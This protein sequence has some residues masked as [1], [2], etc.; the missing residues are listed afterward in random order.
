MIT[1]A[2]TGN[3]EVMRTLRQLS[4]IGTTTF[5][6]SLTFLAGCTGEIASGED[7]VTGGGN[8]TGGSGS[9]STGSGGTD[10]PDNGPPE[11]CIPGIPV[12]TQ[13]PR[14][15]NR[16]YD[17][18]VRDLLGVTTVDSKLPSEQLVDD[19]DGPMTPDAWR[20]YQEVAEKI[21]KAVMAGPNKSKF[22]SCDPSAAGC[23]EQTIKTFGRKAFR[24]PLTDL[25]VARFQ[26]LGQI[27][28]A[29]TPAEVAEA[30]LVG[31]LVSPSF[32]MLPELATD[33]DASGQGIKLSSYE[34]ATKLSYLLWGSAPDEVLSAAADNNELQTKEQI[35][36]QA[37]RM[38]AVREK[39]GPLVTSFHRNWAQMNN[40]NAHWWKMD[41]DTET[42]PL[43]SD[44][45]KPSWQA[46][47]D[48]FFED[49]AFEGGSFDDLL[50]S[51]VA[52]VNKDNA[53][54]Y[55]LD[56]ASYG[57]ELTK[58]E[59]D[60]NVRPGFLT[61]VGFLSSYA[62]YD[63]TSPILRGA[64]ISVY[65]LGVNPGPPIPGA[66]MQ[67]VQGDFA[68]QRA[69]VE[70][71]T[72]PATCNGCH[73]IINPPGFVMEGFDGIGKLQTTDPL[74]GA[75]DASVTTN[76]IDF[77]D[78]NVK[79][80]SSP[81]Q[82]MQE[83][84]QLKKAK[85]LYAEAWVSYAFGRDPNGKDKCVVDQIDTKLSEGGYSILNLLADLTQADSFRVRV[86]ETP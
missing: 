27:T 55:G 67:T 73:S 50:L 10:E 33:P 64:F 3:S 7:E 47:L 9:G 60:A 56:P 4:Y 45:A 40:G 84:A 11:V 15:L 62:G 70:K 23:L 66:T 24:R 58:V 75:I 8:T 68:T 1:P 59:L 52:F 25:E 35:L 32:L 39:T 76:T 19:F 41:H 30:T 61:R 81:L 57:T 28:P 22:I 74:G 12:T 54:I 43:Y 78:G 31:F 20:L 79:E 2:R 48:S 42:Y 5:L 44:A 38:I 18:T 14:L 49:V 71:L 6:A 53:A 17:N 82:L 16:Q 65:L 36:A 13:I 51:N 29:G 46:E 37:Q 21:A 26:K 72:E 69:R 85:Q 63:A 86:R 34:V 80:I 77:G 83:I